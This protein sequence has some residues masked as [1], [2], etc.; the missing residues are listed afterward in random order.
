[1]TMESEFVRFSAARL[2]TLCGRIETCV[3]K[4]TPEQVWMR[5]SENE[6]AV[7]NLLLHLA[8]NVR[9]WILSGVG[10]AADTRERHREFAARDPLP[11]AE[12]TARL[13][14]TVEEAL[15]VIRG[16]PAG[17]LMERVTVQGHDVTKMEAIYTVVE[18]FSGH[19]FQIIFATKLLTGEDLGFYAHLNRP[20]AKNESA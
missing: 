18:H 9:Q 3:A 7:G 5:H 1:M 8:G 14:A 16:L 19:A 13:R 2:E 20:A 11:V 12:L 6:N 17:A 10:G 15:G 4:L